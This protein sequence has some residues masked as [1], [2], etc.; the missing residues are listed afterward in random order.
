MFSWHFTKRV[1]Q[2]GIAA[3]AVAFVKDK[4]FEKE[5]DMFFGFMREARAR[6]VLVGVQ[7]SNTN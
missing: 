1:R 6:Q 7:I 4:G 3:T 2:R 5:H